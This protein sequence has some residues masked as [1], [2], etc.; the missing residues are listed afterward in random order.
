MKI[1]NISHKNF[2]VYRKEIHI[3]SYI[4]GE[5]INKM[6]DS[7]DDHYEANNNPIWTIKQSIIWEVKPL[8]K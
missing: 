4:I 5:E 7:N 3:K 2:C 1:L 8:K 6:N